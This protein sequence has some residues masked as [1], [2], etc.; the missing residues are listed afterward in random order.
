M[1]RRPFLQSLLLLTGGLLLP[2]NHATA[3]ANVAT[4][5]LKGRVTAQGKALANVTVSDG[6]SVV[7]TNA[8]GKYKLPLNKQA[9]FVFLSTPSGYAFPDEKGIARH[10]HPI[11]KTGRQQYNF[12]LTALQTDDTKHNFIIWA[13]PQVKNENDVEQMLT[14]SV[15]D[16][17]QLVRSFGAGALI[18]GVT[19]GDIVWDNHSLFDRYNQAV[20]EMNIPFFQALGNHDMDYNKGGDEVSDDTFESLYGPTHYSFNRGKVHYVVLDDVRYLGEDRK[21]DGYIAQ[22]QL[23]WLKQDLAY[24]PKNNLVIVCLHI[25]VHN[26]V[27]NNAALYALLEGYK[28]HIMSGHTHY[29]RNVIKD[30]IYEHNHGAVCGAWWTGPICGD[31]TP[32]GYGVYEVDGT[33]L[34]WY[35]KPTGLDKNY[36]VSI[37]V[38]Q[39]TN[40][41]RMVANVWNWG[42]EWKVEWWADEKYMGNLQNTKGFDPVAVALY[43]G[44]KLPR[45]RAF[46]EP[47]KTDHLFVA[48]FGPEV[49]KLKVIATDRFGKQYEEQ[50]DIV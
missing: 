32:R 49:K 17:Q 29:N 16:V 46:A 4:T 47:N 37:H 11:T 50:A 48:H 44:D 6:Y 43:K 10:Y 40:Q 13:D 18:H 8:R 7:Q 19:V 3:Q 38:E 1:K 31:G 2:D 27:K 24:V 22:Q 41:N 34:K 25:P 36:Q 23:D 28:A 45:Q 30:G 12:E 42:P 35:Y 33:D 39:L 9:K 15:P 20:A 21:Y 26:G 14:Q 5:K